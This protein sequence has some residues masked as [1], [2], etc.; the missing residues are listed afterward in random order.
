MI[1]ES[2]VNHSLRPIITGVNKM[3]R[4]YMCN[5]NKKCVTNRSSTDVY[6]K[7]QYMKINIGEYSVG[8]PKNPT[9]A[10]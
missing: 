3:I 8:K 2:I 1:Y 9:P 4:C 5:Y 7:N 10:S 6:E